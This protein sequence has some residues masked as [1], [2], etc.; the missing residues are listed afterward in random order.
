MAG[1]KYARNERKKSSD[2]VSQAW[3]WTVLSGF[4]HIVLFYASITLLTG[5]DSK[6]EYASTQLAGA[7]V[8]L[9]IIHRR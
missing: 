9:A 7:L 8:A 2:G 3:Y 1:S 5:Y 4:A 6:A